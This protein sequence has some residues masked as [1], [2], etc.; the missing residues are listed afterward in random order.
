MHI[1]LPRVGSVWILFHH[2]L[3]LLGTREPHFLATNAK[4]A[5]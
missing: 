2:D 3:R 4:S 1:A 5:T